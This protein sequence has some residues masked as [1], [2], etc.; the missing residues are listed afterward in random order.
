MISHDLMQFI[1]A[2]LAVSPFITEHLSHECP[3]FILTIKRLLICLGSIIA[4][5]TGNT[6]I[7]VVGFFVYYSHEI[8]RKALAPASKWFIKKCLTHNMKQHKL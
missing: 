2:F 6:E 5:Y 1:Y 7:L 4:I 3:S 8:S